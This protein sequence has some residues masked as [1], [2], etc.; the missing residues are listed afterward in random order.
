M[1]LEISTNLVCMLLFLCHLSAYIMSQIMQLSW[2]ITFYATGIMIFTWGKKRHKIPLINTEKGHELEHHSNHFK[3]HKKHYNN[4]SELPIETRQNSLR[5]TWNPIATTQKTPKTL[6]V[7]QN[8]LVTTK[9]TIA[10]PWQPSRL[11]SIHAT[12]HHSLTISQKWLA[13]T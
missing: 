7:R 10:T 9:S 3:L 12:T 2:N 4:H 13:T 1:G 8:S 5:V 11:Q 6:Q